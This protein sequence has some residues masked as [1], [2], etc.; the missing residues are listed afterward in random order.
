[1]VLGVDLGSDI[2]THCVILAAD[3]HIVRFSSK[4]K[5]SRQLCVER[6]LPIHAFPLC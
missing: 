6:M 4:Q 1:M 5:W 2:H 3:Y